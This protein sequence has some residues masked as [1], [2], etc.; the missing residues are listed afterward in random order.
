MSPTATTTAKWC[1]KRLRDDPQ[2]SVALGWPVCVGPDP[3]SREPSVSPLLLGD[4]RVFREDE[5]GWRCERTGA[6]VD[7]NSAALGLLGFSYED[8]L[9]IETAIAKSVAVDEAKG[10]RERAEAIL[11]ELVEHGVEGL[12]D[13]GASPLVEIDGRRQR[14][15]VNAAVLL[16]PASSNALILNLA[17]DLRV[18]AAGEEGLGT[19]TGAASAM[20]GG[21]ISDTAS[22]SVDPAPTVGQSSVQQDRAV[23]SAMTNPLTVVPAR[24]VQASRRWS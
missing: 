8:R 1:G 6:G 5:G 19:L 12:A 23:H 3:Q 4:A 9:A 13:I 15:I 7:L 18:L 16:P 22:Q 11:R 21:A 20:F 24:L 14:G 2:G 10:R 17:K